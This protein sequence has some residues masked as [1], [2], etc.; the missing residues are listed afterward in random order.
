MPDEVWPG[1]IDTIRVVSIDPDNDRLRF[2]VDWGESAEVDTYDLVQS[3]ALETYGRHWLIPGSY[4]VRVL[5]LDAHGRPSDWSGLHVNRRSR[6][7]LAVAT[8]KA[9]GR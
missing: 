1:T 8:R 3:A 9:G 2:V 4:P 5:A 7:C 6:T